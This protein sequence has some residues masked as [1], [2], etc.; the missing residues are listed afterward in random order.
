MH[1]SVWCGVALLCSGV[2]CA[3]NCVDFHDCKT[4]NV[5]VTKANTSCQWQICI[6]VSEGCVANVSANCT[7]MNETMCA[8]PTMSTPVP[9]PTKSTPAPAHTTAVSTPASPTNS[10]NTTS[11]VTVVTLTPNTTSLTTTPG[12]TN[13]T[14]TAPPLPHRNSTFDAASFIGG[15]VLVLGLQAVIFFAVKFCKSKDRNYHTL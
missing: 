1:W 3:E 4:C 12:T 11:G 10:S 6:G 8:V 7:E 5:N 15:I 13:G 9:T 2:F 14:T